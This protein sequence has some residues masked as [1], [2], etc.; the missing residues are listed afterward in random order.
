MDS[1]SMSIMR[2][3]I[4]LYTNWSMIRKTNASQHSRQS[5]KRDPYKQNDVN[6]LNFYKN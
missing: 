4:F 5:G 1:I 3:N 2:G 6:E